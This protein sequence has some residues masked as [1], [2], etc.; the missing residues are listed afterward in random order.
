MQVS[1]VTVPP[2]H[3]S[4]DMSNECGLQFLLK[5]AS[6]VYT[7]HELSAQHRLKHKTSSVDTS[8]VLFLAPT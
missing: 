7:L 4:N 1:S 6:R 8:L 5:G 2:A 3:Y